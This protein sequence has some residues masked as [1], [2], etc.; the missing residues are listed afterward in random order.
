[1]N[2]VI[3]KHTIFILL[4]HTHTYAYTYRRTYAAQF[5]LLQMHIFGSYP[6][7]TA[8]HYDRINWIGYFILL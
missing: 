2:Y 6:H 4:L 5:L 8:L 7:V 3:Y 1:M